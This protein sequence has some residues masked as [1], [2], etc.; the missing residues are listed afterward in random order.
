MA[1][2]YRQSVIVLPALEIWF[3]HE[4]LSQDSIASHS[5][6]GY[7][8]RQSDSD[9]HFVSEQQRR[10]L[11]KFIAHKEKRL[12]MNLR[13]DSKGK[14]DPER[15]FYDQQIEFYLASALLVAVHQKDICRLTNERPESV[16]TRVWRDDLISQ[17]Q[18]F[19]VSLMVYF[20]ASMT[21][22]PYLSSKTMRG[23]PPDLTQLRMITGLSVPLSTEDLWDSTLRAFGFNFNGSASG[24]IMP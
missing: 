17:S 20:R 18:S 19:T 12:L 9:T 22:A 14:L 10:D 24:Y 7:K 21:K 4:L 1:Y 6:S 5:P 3:A 2:K 23:E 11:E 16:E 13:F 15:T 8:V